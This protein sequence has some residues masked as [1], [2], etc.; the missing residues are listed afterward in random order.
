MAMIGKMTALLLAVGTVSTVLAEPKPAI[1][2]FQ[3]DRFGL[4]LHWGCYAQIGKGEWNMFFERA[5]VSE[6]AKLAATFDPVSFDARQW[7]RVAKNAG[8]KYI[9]LTTKHHDGFCLFD[10]RYSDFTSVKCSPQHRDYVREFVD[11]CREYGLK[12]GF[13]YS[14]LDWRFRGYFHY[15]TDT[16]SAD[17][18]RSQCHNQVIELMTNYG[19][20]DVLWYDGLWLAHDAK[21]DTTD[22]P[23]FWQGDKLNARV[24]ELQPEIVINNRLGQPEDFDTPEGRIVLPKEK[25]RP[26]EYC[27]TMTSGWGFYGGDEDHAKDPNFVLYNLIDAVSQGGNYLCNVGVNP[28]GL[29]PSAAVDTLNR[30]GEWMKVNGEAVYG[31]TR[32]DFQDDPYGWTQKG[33]VY[34]FTLFSCPLDGRKVFPLMDAK[35][36]K[37]EILGSTAKP[38]VTYESNGRL[39]VNG[40]PRKPPVPPF[41]TLKFEFEKK[42]RKIEEPKERLGD[43]LTG[44]MN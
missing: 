25:G 31:A 12:I 14:Q 24:R 40:L 3:A 32:N 27:N 26:W 29:L 7:A 41:M 18:L 43:W 2:A 11:A 5:P 22:S 42:P 36:K 10:S 37:V 20:I 34:Y 21:T 15:K 35:V 8:F 13:Y 1:R 30:V 17:A 9:V 19:K 38:T 16:K 23:V 33:D 39:C 28:E 6:Y 44:S 4:F